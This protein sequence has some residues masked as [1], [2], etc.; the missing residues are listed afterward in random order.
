[1]LPEV[2]LLK[3]TVVIV[4]HVNCAVGVTCFQS[5]FSYPEMQPLLKHFCVY[6]VSAPGQ[7][8]NAPLINIG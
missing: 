1:M 8:D 3:I 7:R 4:I 2:K 6:H 5:F